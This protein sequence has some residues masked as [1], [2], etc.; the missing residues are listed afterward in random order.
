MLPIANVIE[1]L[2]RFTADLWQIHPFREGN[3][4]TTAVFLIKYLRSLGVAVENDMFREHS[5]YFRNALVRATY[6]GLNVQPTTAFVER[7]LRNIILGENNELRN[8]DMRVEVGADLGQLQS[9]MPTAPKCNN[10]TL[11]CTLDELAILRCIEAN[12]RITQKEMAAAIGKSERTV[13]SLTTSLTA[14]G[15]IARRNGRRNGLWEILF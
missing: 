11:N 6:R 10:C 3:T 13:K 12:P 8:R 1:H 7:F 5:W 2:A 9:A 14:K 15:I 4:R